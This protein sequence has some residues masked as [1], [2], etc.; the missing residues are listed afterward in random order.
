[1]IATNGKKACVIM[2]GDKVV[3]KILVL[4]PVYELEGDML[5]KFAVDVKKGTT[6]FMID[7]STEVTANDDYKAGD[8]LYFSKGTFHPTRVQFRVNDNV[9][10]NY[11]SEV[12][13][14]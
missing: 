14:L 6:L 3:T 9:C 1:M 7:D 5:L 4:Q 12:R 8:Y 11:Y 2:D 13:F 10:Y